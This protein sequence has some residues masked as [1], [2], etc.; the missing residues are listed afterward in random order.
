M[1]GIH[2]PLSPVSHVQFSCAQNLHIVLP[3]VPWL[4]RRKLPKIL[5]PGKKK[6]KR[7][8]CFPRE[9]TF[10]ESFKE[11]SVSAN[12]TYRLAYGEREL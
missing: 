4:R 10:F 8:K 6:R 7:K 11:V 3:R 5:N 12:S 9:A 1:D 2:F